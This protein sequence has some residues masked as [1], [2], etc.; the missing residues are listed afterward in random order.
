MKNN[1]GRALCRHVAV[2]ALLVLA[3]AA[4]PTALRAESGDLGVPYAQPLA[5]ESSSPVQTPETVI[6]DWPETSRTIA[7]AMIQ[8]YGEPT[9]F[10]DDALIW[11]DNGPWKK[12]V[13]YRGAWPHYTGR[14]DKDYLEQ[15]IA[16]RVPD[17][18][19]EALMR[20]DDRIRI[21]QSRGELSARSESEEMNYL[22]INL[23]EEIITGKR[24][25]EG[26]REFCRKTEDLSASGKSSPYQH[27]FVFRID[28]DR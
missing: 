22:T 28:N 24:S 23:A 11:Y 18:K 7:L 21:D 20:F 9:R 16:Y 8:G 1:I 19:F 2:P 17:G 14:K 15:T 3:V 4:A 26:A 12:S 27:G 6:K 25:V 13:V 5:L 10:T